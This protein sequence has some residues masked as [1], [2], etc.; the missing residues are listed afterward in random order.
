MAKMRVGNLD[1]NSSVSIFQTFSSE[2]LT[3][4]LL[5]WLRACKSGDS[6][7]V[8]QIEEYRQA[9]D[10]ELKKSLPLATVGA[11]CEGGRKMENVVTRTGWIAL[12]IDAKDN[13]H[14]N[15]AEHL[16]DEVAKISNV[17]FCGLSVSG[18]GVWSLVKVK[19]PD[20]QA[21]HFEALIKDFSSFG[22]VLDSTK[23]RN[24]NDARFYSYDSDAI[25]KDSFVI[26]EK[27]P[28]KQPKPA[29]AKPVA[30]G[31]RYAQAAFT[32]E[33]ETLATTPQGNR[34]NQLYKS[35]AALGSLVAGGMLNETEVRQSLEET[36]S[37]IGLKPHEITTTLN[38]GFDAGFATPRTPDAN[39]VKTAV[40]NHYGEG[41][42]PTETKFESH[43]N[44]NHAKIGEL[45]RRDPIIGDVINIFDAE[46]ENLNE[47]QLTN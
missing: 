40:A 45:I 2:P 46:I 4:P 23:G 21:E 14:L 17:A 8:K 9:G 1:M 34:N 47:I 19:H 43:Q 41:V 18:K 3:V 13:P 44:P 5:R 22:I 10:P 16:R 36:A 32:D 6:R 11:V 30:N 42:R 20:R 28:P 7:Y 35:A 15:N 39:G 24:P 27:L 25:I 38:S 29:P 26:Y 12:D 37:A 33:L 31:S